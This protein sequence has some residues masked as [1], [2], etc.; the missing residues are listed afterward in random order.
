MNAA[1]V[2]R[3]ARPAKP[4]LSRELVIETGLRILDTDG[5]AALTMRRVA[6]ELD[7]GAA[8]LYVYVAH[9][10]DLMTA[11]LDHVLAQIPVPTSGDWRGRLTALVDAAIEAL[12]RHDGLAL[13]G[14]GRTPTTD[15]ARALV[16]RLVVLLRE[17][18]L[19]GE[20]AGWA[21]RLIQRHIA[22]EAV[23]RV[24]LGASQDSLD[25][26]R[27]ALNA[28]LNGI[29][30]T[31]RGD[32]RVRTQRPAVTGG[33]V[34]P[35]REDEIGALQEI[36]V[37]AGAP[38]A[39]VGMIAVAED[40]PPSREMLRAFVIEGRA[41]VWPDEHDRP[42]GYLVLDFVDG[43]PHIE[44]VSVDPAYAGARIGKRLIDYAVRWSKDRGLHQITLTTFTQVPWNGP[45]YE[46]LG[47]AYI[48]AA[49]EPP[50]LRAIRATELAHGLDEWPRASMR[51]ELASW[52]FD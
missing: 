17:G 19:D 5:C 7:T 9:R 15:H 38:F 26:A 1:P 20:T 12:G 25:R 22:A 46:R 50:G 23:E 40:E 27:W 11:M 45:Y 51:A 49:D 43:V 47:F 52:V 21:V 37:R 29:L 41:W 4:P 6:Q 14:F 44:Q 10:D 36:E 2:S 13:V 30:A 28:L 33:P 42:I 8:S 32:G 39:Q 3:R 24:A 34:R 16:E 31:P 35:A 18:G 48:A